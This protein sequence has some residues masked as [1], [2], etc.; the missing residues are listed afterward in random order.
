MAIQAHRQHKDLQGASKLA[1]AGCSGR[2][3]DYAHDDLNRVGLS[4]A[5]LAL[6]PALSG[7]WPP[8]EEVVDDLTVACLLTIVSANPTTA[9]LGCLLFGQDH[10]RFRP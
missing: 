6:V 1:G 10:S 4:L 5:Y 3:E 8:P 2:S 7:S 9:V